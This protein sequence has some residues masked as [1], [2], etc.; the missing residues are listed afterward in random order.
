M[1]QV[2]KNDRFIEL[3]VRHNTLFHVDNIEELDE[4]IRVKKENNLPK[5][6]VLLRFSGI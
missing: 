3:G 2:L 5:V 6:S 1:E 4:I